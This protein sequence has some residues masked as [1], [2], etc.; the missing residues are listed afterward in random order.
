[1][2]IVCTGYEGVIGTRLV[3]Q[4]CTPLLCDVT[5]LKE[6]KKAIENER[7]DVVI[8]CA[9]L[10]DVAYCEDHFKESFEVNVRGTSNV[11][12]STR[13]DCLFIYL[14]TDHIFSGD[15][16]FNSGYGE[17]HKP[18]PVNRYGFSKWGGEIAANTGDCRTIIVRSSKLF[19]YNSIKPTIDKLKDGET[20]I[21]T[22]LLR[23][24]FY[25]VNHFVD[26][27]LYL[28]HNYEKYPKLE[29]LNISGQDVISYYL[30][31]N[32]LNEYLGLSGN[33]KPR[34]EELKDET[35]RPFRAGLE[36]YQMKRLGIPQS[37]LKDGFE[38]IKQGI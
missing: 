35:P 31:W 4:G 3:S 14:S 5:K 32:S 21:F 30:F 18:S 17:N 8:H 19:Y 15:M 29:I 27:L 25:H 23:R 12:E 33:V 26:G 6:V 2:K 20:V 11:V 10:T 24:S 13:R 9:A 34:R 38:L 36:T 28:A 1:M 7:P 22:D 37:T 16:W